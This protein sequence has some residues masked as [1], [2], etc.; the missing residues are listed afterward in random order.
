MK[1]FGI[2]VAGF[3]AGFATL[4]GLILIFGDYEDEPTVAPVAVAQELQPTPAGLTYEAVCEVNESDMTDP[5]IAAF[6]AKYV[7]QRFTAWHG[8]V[9]DVE[10]RADGTYNLLIAM[11]ERS[12][13]W[14]RDVVIENIPTD[15]ATRLNVEQPIT[16]SGRIARN[17]VFLEGVCNPLVI[18]DY[19]LQE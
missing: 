1:T 4:F 16:F 5:Q 19:T 8:W 11:S 10:S 17:D 3:V 2:F 12:L 9:Y 18:D 6:A 7:G 13:V 14:G 15:L